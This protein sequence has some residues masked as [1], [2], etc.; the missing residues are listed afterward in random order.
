MVV[1]RRRSGMMRLEEVVVGGQD[2]QSKASYKYLAQPVLLHA[3]VRECFHGLREAFP[4]R[5]R[6]P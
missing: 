3:F 1:G 6:F 2:R 5:E 4:L